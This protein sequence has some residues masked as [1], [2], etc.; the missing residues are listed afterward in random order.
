MDTNIGIVLRLVRTR[1]GMSLAAVAAGAGT[2]F[3][4]LSYIER[5]L[6]SPSSEMLLAICQALKVPMS[7]VL[8]EA[9]FLLEAA[10]R[11]SIVAVA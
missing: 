3:S 6:K 7:T 9:S 5:G 4:H 1:R 10:E 2:T 11:R 8:L